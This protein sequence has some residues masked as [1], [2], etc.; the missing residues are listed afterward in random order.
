MTFL[1]TIPLTYNLGPTFLYRSVYSFVKNDSVNV[2]FQKKIISTHRFK[3]ELYLRILDIGRTY[4]CG[5]F[6]PQS[7]S[8]VAL[9]ERATVVK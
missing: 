8:P 9:A 3:F 6:D 5:R 4:G 7:L 2:V 1:S